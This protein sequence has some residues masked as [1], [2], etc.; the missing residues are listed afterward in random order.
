MTEDDAWEMLEEKQRLNE[1]NRV[2]LKAWDESGK[3]VDENASSLGMMTMRK[4]FEIGY[5]FGYEDA[6][7]EFKKK[8]SVAHLSMSRIKSRC[9]EKVLATLF[10]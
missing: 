1:I 8:W 10:L 9:G 4:V 6:K 2:R 7:Q 5:R 3:F